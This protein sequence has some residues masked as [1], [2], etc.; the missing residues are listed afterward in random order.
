VLTITLVSLPRATY[1][2]QIKNEMKQRVLI[3]VAIGGSKKSR[4]KVLKIAAT[5]SGVESVTMKGEQN[6]QLQVIGEGIDAL[7]LA[8]LLRK[9]VGN[10]DLLS[11]GPAKYENE[12][13]EFV[14]QVTWPYQYSPSPYASVPNASPYHVSGPPSYPA[15]A[16]RDSYI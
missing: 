2:L 1:I 12:I 5:F 10:A 13:I 16:V 3:K 8:K 11:L 14:D 7:K 9:S 6:D 4:G 15:Y